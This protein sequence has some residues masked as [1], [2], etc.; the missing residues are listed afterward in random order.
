MP[1]P[2]SDPGDMGKESPV[3]E[4]I[5]VETGD[6]PTAPEEQETVNK[7][8]DRSHVVAVQ[9]GRF[10]LLPERANERLDLHD[11]VHAGRGRGFDLDCRFGVKGR[12]AGD[13]HACR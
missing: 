12:R 2:G 4:S 9:D 7:V 5:T 1:G 6:D 11:L 8:G 10:A 3:V 13:G